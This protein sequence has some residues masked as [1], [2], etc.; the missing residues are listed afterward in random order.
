VERKE[1]MKTNGKKEINNKEFEQKEKA[2]KLDK[3]PANLH[4][5]IS[6]FVT[7]NAC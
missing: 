4:L 7:N 2:D 1:C 6:I 5:V 3:T